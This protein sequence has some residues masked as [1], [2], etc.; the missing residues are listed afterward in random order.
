ML[1]RAKDPKTHYYLLWRVTGHLSIR[2][3]T[4]R[5][6]RLPPPLIRK[7]RFRRKTLVL[8]L[9]KRGGSDR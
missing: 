8:D 1:L 2:K 6:M 4:G 3:V 5:R 7:A 9:R